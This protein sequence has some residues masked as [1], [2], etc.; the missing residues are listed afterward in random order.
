[1]ELRISNRVITAPVKSI[2]EQ[3]RKISHKRYLRDQ[4]DKD[5]NIIVTCPFHKDGQETHPSCSVYTR[6]DSSKV[7]YGTY[8]CFACGA[9]GSLMDLVCT[10]TGWSVENSEQWLIDNFSSIYLE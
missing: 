5:E 1:M 9:A 6:S 2:L 10:S 8:H 4:V 3:L 7:D